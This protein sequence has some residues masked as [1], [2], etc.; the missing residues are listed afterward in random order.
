SES[1]ASGEALYQEEIPEFIKEIPSIEGFTKEK[2]ADTI[3][4]IKDVPDVGTKGKK[5]KNVPKT[6]FKTLIWIMAIFIV[7][8]F[9]VLGLNLFG[10]TEILAPLEDGKIN[11]LLVGV[12]ESGLRTDAIMVASYNVNE[13]QINL[14]SI[15]RDTKIFVKNRKMTRKINEIHAISSNEERGY[16]LGTQATAEAVTALTGLPIN[17]YVEFSFASIDH[18][19]DI[20]G[21][22]EFD[23]PDV[24]GNGEGMNYDDP[25]QNL[26]IHLKPGLQKLS[27]NQIQQFLRYRK[28][29]SGKGTGSDTDRVERQQLFIK[30]VI[31]QK[32][33]LSTLLK[34]PSIFTQ[35]SREIKTNISLND[36]TKYVRYLSKLSSEGITTYS[37][38]GGAKSIGGASYFVC[39][40]EATELLMKDT[41]GASGEIDDQVSLSEKNP[42]KPLKVTNV[43]ITPE[44]TKAPKE[45]PKKEDTKKDDDP[46]KEA[47]K[48]PAV[49]KE[50]TKAPAVT[51]EPT[52][53][54]EVTKE[55][56]ENLEDEDEQEDEIMI[57]E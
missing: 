7:L 21:P 8:V 44:P 20:L 6:I 23:V 32:V 39:D 30:A 51:K 13:G 53:A 56:L 45:E 37:L 19:F 16:I 4:N 42:Q 25:H 24:E 17:Y 33:N 1:E 29:N 48:A 27:G 46:D 34:L 18:L 14:L 9:S 54:P 3:P 43:T 12:D 47:T 35:L 41:F 40:I 50:P 52:K 36:I 55:P 49:T 57:L 5:K 28:S 15:P 10:D 22:V 11:V 31:D 26:H 2:A 38:P